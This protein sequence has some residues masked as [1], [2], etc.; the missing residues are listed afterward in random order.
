MWNPTG[1][2][3]QFL[4]RASYFQV[5]VTI[6]LTSL[7]SSVP[8][9]VPQERRGKEMVCPWST[10]FAE[11]PFYALSE[12][13][14]ALVKVMFSLASIPKQEFHTKFLV[15]ILARMIRITLRLKKFALLFSFNHLV[16]HGKVA[17][18]SQLK[19]CSSAALPSWG[20]HRAVGAELIRPQPG[21]F[22]V[23]MDLRKV[24]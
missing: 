16:P 3:S 8:L 20:I 14:G 10:I 15:M 18:M 4:S 7:Y 2:G 22:V 21:L 9:F 19:L 23:L 17:P 1:E 13:L 5:L 11:V 24:F 6:S 12:G